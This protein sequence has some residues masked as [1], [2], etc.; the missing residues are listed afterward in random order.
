M[1]FIEFSKTN[2]RFICFYFRIFPRTSKNQNYKVFH[3]LT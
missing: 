1:G 2:S 3:N